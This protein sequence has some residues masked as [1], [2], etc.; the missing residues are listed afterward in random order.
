MK[1][2]GLLGRRPF[3]ELYQQLAGDISNFT[4]MKMAGGK[5][6][7]AKEYYGCQNCRAVP[8]GVNISNIG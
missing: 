1:V 2:A 6:G 3:F 5:D 4:G 8:H 7:K